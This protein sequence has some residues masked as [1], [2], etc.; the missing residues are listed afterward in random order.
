M[1]D[2]EADWIGNPD[3]GN[4]NTVSQEDYDFY[5]QDDIRKES[6]IQA[7]LQELKNQ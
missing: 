2:I 7:D 6:Q 4:S 3:Y 5:W 1:V